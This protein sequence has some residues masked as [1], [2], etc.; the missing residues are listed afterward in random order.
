[1]EQ[2]LVEFAE[3][4]KLTLIREKTISSIHCGVETLMDFL[5][6]TEKNELIIYDL[7]N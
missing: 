1:M 4:A 3:V 5:L 7:D 2:Q 6:E